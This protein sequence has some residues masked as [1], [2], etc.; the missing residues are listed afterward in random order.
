M[1]ANSSES[2]KANLG[3]ESGGR[4]M[5]PQRSR[6]YF[7]IPNQEIPLIDPQLRPLI[8]RAER[9]LAQLEAWLPPAPP[10]IDWSA[11]AYRWRRRGARGWLD[12]VTR[13]APIHLDDLQ[14][15]ERQKAVLQRNT[16]AFL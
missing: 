14:H 2:L 9:V 8:E 5:R 4:N 11:H 6:L 3:S 1:G 12:A 10:P 16:L 15:V 7:P 13:I